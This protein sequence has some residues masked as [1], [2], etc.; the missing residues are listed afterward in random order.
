MEQPSAPWQVQATQ[1]ECIGHVLYEYPHPVSVKHAIE[2]VT[3]RAAEPI[4]QRDDGHTRYVR[5][6]GCRWWPEDAYARAR[7]RQR[8]CEKNSVVS[9]TAAIGRIFSRENTPRVHR[10]V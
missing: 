10:V 3:A 5:R 9:D 1:A 4:G 6:R 7:R 8:L 2:L